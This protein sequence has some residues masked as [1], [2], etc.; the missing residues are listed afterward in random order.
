MPLNTVIF[1]GNINAKIMLV[2]EA[3]GEQED[4]NGRPF[5]GRSGKLLD[6][7]FEAID[8]SRSDLYITNTV[9]WRPPGN[10]KPT[11]EE[12]EICK[13]FVEK[14]IAIIKPKLLI[15][16]GGVATETMLKTGM[17]ISK[18]RGKFFKYTNRY[19]QDS[20]DVTPIFHPAYL[21][22]QPAQK[23]IAWEDLQNIR[24]F[25]DGNLPNY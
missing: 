9:F 19:L 20:I 16:V 13:P 12:T 11:I 1:D 18:M 14:N 8:L 2:G 7:M 3:P 21:L 23:K 22:R 15:L 10:R 5:C 6:R 4:I 25:I 17:S 24:K